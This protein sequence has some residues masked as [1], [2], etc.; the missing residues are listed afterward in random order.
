[1][2]V[3]LQLA[4]PQRILQVSSV[5]AVEDA[6]VPTYAIRGDD[7]SAVDEVR[8]DEVA[9]P[10]VII[11]SKHLLLAVV[12]EVLRSQVTYNITVV[13][14]GVA[15]TEKSV[16][17]FRFG[18]SNGR[19]VGGSKLVQL[20]LKVLLSE[21]GSDIFSPTLGGGALRDLGQT[22]SKSAAGSLLGNF[23]IAVDA[24]ARQ[25]QALQSHSVKTP[26]S[27][28]LLSAKVASAHFDEAETALIVSIQ[29]TSQAGT[30][31]QA[32]LVL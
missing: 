16:V 6:D 5:Q 13:S 18:R 22:F 2:A 12:P 23:V 30:T 17:A 1:M 7:F 20:F 19:V 28:R 32:N 21:P 11:R 4:F 10:S 3:D 24:T 8:F 26:L 29:L 27:E 25:V 31:S 15:H 9:S 14:F